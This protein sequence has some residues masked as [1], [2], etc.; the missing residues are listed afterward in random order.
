MKL[1]STLAEIASIEAE[2][3]WGSSDAYAD[4]F[5]RSYGQP[6]DDGAF[7]EAVD[8]MVGDLGPEA[9]GMGQALTAGATDYQIQDLQ[10]KDDIN[11]VV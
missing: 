10:A 6:T 7:N 5:V 1:R 9:T 2:Q 3:P 11:R 4:A 8:T